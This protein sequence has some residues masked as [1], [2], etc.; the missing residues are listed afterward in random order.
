MRSRY[1]LATPQQGFTRLRLD[2][3]GPC[4][5]ERGERALGIAAQPAH[6]AE[7][8][9]ALPAAQLLT[10]S[11]PGWRRP[12]GPRARGS[13]RRRPAVA[14]GARRTPRPR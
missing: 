14:A 10:S 4:A 1:A 13:H 8:V 2:A 9:V 5:G 7:L 12:A 3:Q 6:L 11:N